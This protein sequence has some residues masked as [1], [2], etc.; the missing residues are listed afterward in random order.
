LP[1]RDTRHSLA[2][3]IAAHRAGKL[4][5]Q[6]QLSRL[7]DLAIGSDVLKP[8]G[9][10]G[11]RTARLGEEGQQVLSDVKDVLERVKRWGE[12]KN[13]DDLCQNIVWEVGTADVGVDVGELRACFLRLL[14]FSSLLFSSLRPR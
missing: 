13:G 14:L 6:S 10:A 5:S 9:G 2:A 11:S 3:A 8:G 4:P 1:S 12:E 7:I